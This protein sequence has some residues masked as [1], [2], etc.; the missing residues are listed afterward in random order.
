[1]ERQHEYVW[2]DL[3]T[4]GLIPQECQILE[5]AIALVADDQQGDMSIVEERTGVIHTPMSPAMD[6]FVRKMHTRNG[7]L[8]ACL[9]APATQTIA[10]AEKQLLQLMQDIGAQPRSVLLAGNSVHFDLGFLRVH[11]PDFA[12]YL[13]HRV[14]DVSTLMLASRAWLGTDFKKNEAHRALADV[15]ESVAFAKRCRDIAY[16]TRS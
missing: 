14:F 11:M 1:M 4:T 7:L 8:D 6:D 9:V 3:E 10:D 13:S 15:R 12:K 2:L 16:A 5:W